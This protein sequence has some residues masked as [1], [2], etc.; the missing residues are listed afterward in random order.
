MIKKVRDL[1]FNEVIKICKKYHKKRTRCCNNKCPIFK[2]GTNFC[3]AYIE[4]SALLDKEVEID[5]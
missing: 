1:T 3:I 5:D 2:I 4:D